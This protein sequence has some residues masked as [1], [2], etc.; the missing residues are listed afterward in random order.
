LS[1]TIAI[2]NSQISQLRSKYPNDRFS[3]D[4]K[5]FNIL[6]EESISSTLTSDGIVQIETIR[7]KTI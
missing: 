7:E 3:L 2:F 6:N 1:N 5:V 4:E